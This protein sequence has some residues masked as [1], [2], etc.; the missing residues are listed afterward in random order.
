[1]SILEEHLVHSPI[2]VAFLPSEPQRAI[3]RGLSRKS[4]E[5]AEMYIGALRVL[6]DN[7]NPDRLYQS[8]HS[9]RELMEKM[10]LFW[11]ETPVFKK[12]KPGDGIKSQL[13]PRKRRWNNLKDNCS[14]AKNDWHGTIGDSLRGFLNDL[15]AFFQW[16][17]KHYPEQQ[18]QTTS[19][20]NTL[21]P[22][23]GSLPA[24][25]NDR[26]EK[27]RS[28]KWMNLSSQITN[29]SHHSPTNLKYLDTLSEFESL[30]LNEILFIVQPI[31][32]SDLE[33]LDALI[34]EVESDD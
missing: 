5:L 31:V 11:E 27:Q 12:K 15:D 25:E 14:E 19:F 4:E 21:A 32:L 29:Y 2:E 6:L 22:F 17:E 18:S 34:L 20:L 33:L 30:L 23:A 1:M 3:I 16:Y 10:P 26:K 9:I 28:D 13:N 8:A 7:Q 24:E